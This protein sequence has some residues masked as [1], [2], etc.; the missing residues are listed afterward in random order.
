MAH[1]P[2]MFTRESVPMFVVL[3][4]CIASS[5]YPSLHNSFGLLLR[6]SE[7]TRVVPETQ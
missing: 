3:Y 1:V 5:E 2:Y 4:S 7:D 6:K